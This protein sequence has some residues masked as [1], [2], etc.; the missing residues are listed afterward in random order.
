[1]CFLSLHICRNSDM[2]IPLDVTNTEELTVTNQESQLY[3]EIG[4]MNTPTS[5]GNTGVSSSAPGTG[6]AAL[7]VQYEYE[8][9]QPV[10]S[11]VTKSSDPYD[12][13]LCSA[14]GVSLHQDRK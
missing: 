14:Y 1:M 4:G 7:R 11:G 8:D 9:I 6:T 5:T 12:I 10:G 13:T 3:E 2:Q